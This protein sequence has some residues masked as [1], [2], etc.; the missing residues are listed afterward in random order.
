MLAAVQCRAMD[1][2]FARA[3]AAKNGVG[4]KAVRKIFR[5]ESM[6]CKWEAA[7]IEYDAS[8]KLHARRA[9]AGTLARR[10]VRSPRCL[11][12]R[13]A[14]RAIKQRRHVDAPPGFA[15]RRGF[16][17]VRAASFLV[18]AN[19]SRQFK[20]LARGDAMRGPKKTAR[21]VC[22]TRGTRAATR[23]KSAFLKSPYVR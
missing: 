6:H 17:G 19:A 11:F 8:S 7:L 23:A 4:K 18:R 1:A 22:V 12:A 15:P 13:C 2:G 5:A 3:C 14:V 9:A 20:K 21:G 16:F 10:C